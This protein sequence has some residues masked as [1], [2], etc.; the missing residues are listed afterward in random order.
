[1]KS[2]SILENEMLSTKDQDLEEKPI[3]FPVCR[4]SPPYL[5]TSEEIKAIDKIF[6]EQNILK[7]IYGKNLM[8]EAEANKNKKDLNVKYNNSKILIQIDNFNIP[9]INI[10]FEL[11][12]LEL[13]RLLKE[14]FSCSSIICYFA[15]NLAGNR[16]HMTLDGQNINYFIGSP[17]DIFFKCLNNLERS[18][19]DNLTSLGVKAVLLGFKNIFNVFDEGNRQWQIREPR[20]FYGRFKSIKNFDM[21]HAKI[22]QQLKR[23]HLYLSSLIKFSKYYF[24]FSTQSMMLYDINFRLTD[25]VDYFCIKNVIVDGTKLII[26]YTEVIDGENKWICN[27]E[28]EDQAKTIKEILDKE[29]IKN[30]DDLNNL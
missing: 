20:A 6:S 23:S 13:E 4:V 1:N 8:K 10:Q 12:K 25:N 2:S 14:R 30:A 29:Q 17:E 15:K 21:I 19:L 7:F 22:Y 5:K 28:N 9:S 27:C 18:I 26:K 24:V 11:S 16:M 3:D